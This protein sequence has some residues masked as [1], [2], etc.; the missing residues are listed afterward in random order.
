MESL[1]ANL[2]RELWNYKIPGSNLQ[3]CPPMRKH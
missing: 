2:M 1:K 3:P